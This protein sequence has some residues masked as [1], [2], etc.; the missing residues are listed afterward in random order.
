MVGD[1][2]GM[3]SSQDPLGLYLH[4]PFC[5]SKCPYC[6]FYSTAA[7]D[8]QLLDRY[9]KALE[10]ALIRWR[11]QT[12]GPADTLYFGGGTPS[13]LGGRRLA[14][15]IDR[16]VSL[17]GLAGAEITLEANPAD[18]LSEVFR[19]FAAA[20]G[21]RLSL[22][23][24]TANP[25]ELRVLGRRHTPAELGR[26]VDAAH[27]A[28][29]SNLSLDLMLGIPRQDE[30]SVANAVEACRRLEARHVSAYLLK[31]EPGTPFA[32]QAASLELPDEDAAAD[33]YLAACAELASAGYRQYEISNFALPG[34]ESRHNRKYWEGAPYL[35]VGPSAHSFLGGRRFFYPRSLPAFLRGE[36]PVLENSRDGALADGSPAEYLMLRLRLTEGLT[37]EAYR[38]RFGAPI[39]L[40]W[41]ERAAALPRSHILCDEA[42]IRLTR[43]GFLVS[44]VLIGRLLE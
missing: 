6:D 21:N 28:G 15:L 29:I 5:V 2:N 43:E 9:T 11:E 32:A 27:A 22:G 3:T 25:D 26:A 12:A 14:R 34:F 17:Y 13:L 31:I 18:N 7:F 40:L 41:R 35:G 4:V 10:Q 42:G 44:N 33:R 16:A 23:M 19:A 20:G 37:E 36:P 24:Q 30:E 1:G 8:E 38:T 39:P